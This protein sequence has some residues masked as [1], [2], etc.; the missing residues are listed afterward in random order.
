VEQA[1]ERLTERLS[2]L[3][4]HDVLMSAGGDVILACA[5]TDTPDWSIGIE[6]P[7]DRQRL[8]MTLPMRRGAVATSGIAARGQHIVDPSTGRPPT[9]LLSATVIGP[10]LTWADVY[11]TAAVVKGADADRWVSTLANHAGVLVG[12][13]GAV[14]TVSASL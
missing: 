8:V 13:D 11:A 3:G 6:D 5:R 10:S 1:F 2:A 9:G 14:R 7:R 12:T 4:A